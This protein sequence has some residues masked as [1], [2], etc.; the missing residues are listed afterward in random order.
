VSSESK[1][2]KILAHFIAGHSLTENQALAMFR[3][4]RLAALAHR[5]RE[6]GHDIRCRMVKDPSTG[7]TYGEW[8]YVP[9]PIK[10]EQTAINFSTTTQQ[11]S[12][13]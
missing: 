3:A 6:R 7:D 11:G 2:A 10:P 12:K 13:P 8:Y 9:P 5:F 1:T 4:R